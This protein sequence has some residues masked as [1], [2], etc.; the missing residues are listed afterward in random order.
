MFKNLIPNNHRRNRLANSRQTALNLTLLESRTVPAVLMTSGALASQPTWGIQPSTPISINPTT[1]YHGIAIVTRDIDNQPIDFNQDGFP[2]MAQ[3]GGNTGAVGYTSTETAYISF[4]RAGF[5]KIAFGSANGLVY[6]TKGGK[7]DVQIPLQFGGTQYAVADLNQDGFQDI[8]ALQSSPN[9]PGK[10]ITGHYLWD[11]TAQDFAHVEGTVLDVTDYKFGQMDLKDVNGDQIPDLV[12]PIF[13]T[14]PVNNPYN[15]DVTGYKVLPM[16]GFQVNLGVSDPTFGHWAGDFAPTAYTSVSLR[17]PNV[18]FGVPVDVSPTGDIRVAGPSTY[19]PVVNTVLVDLNGDG[20]RDL[21]I[22]EVD[23]ISLFANP[24]SGLFGQATGQFF[25]TAGGANGLN[26][27][28]GDFNNDGKPDLATSPNV[29]AIGLMSVVSPT[30]S[31][32]MANNSP[33]SVFLNTTQAAGAIDLSM[34]A[35]PGF[36]TSGF[37]WNGSLATADFNGD[38]NLDLAVGSGENQSTSY[39]I[40]EGDGQGNFGTMVRFNGYTNAADGYV[41]DFSR[42][43]NYLNVA[44]FN[45][46]GQVDVVVSSLNIGPGGS[47]QSTGKANSAV[48][49]TGLALNQTFGTPM[50][51]AAAIPAATVGQPYSQQLLVIGGDPSKPFAFALN[52][53]SVALPTGLTLSPTGL[54]SGTPTQTGPFQLILDISQPNGPRGTSMGTLMV[55]NAIPGVL[56]ISPATLPAGT[57]GTAYSQQLTVTGATGAVSWAVTS[58]ALPQGLSL[59]AGGL[60]SGTPSSTGAASFTVGATDSAGNTGYRQYSLTIGTN[61]TPPLAGPFIAAGQGQGGL[62]SIFNADGSQRS[63]FAPYGTG[64]KGSVTVA[65]GDVNGD[66][67]ADLV[68]GTGAGSEP[69]V[70]V[71]DGNTLAPIGSFYAYAQAFRGGVRVAAGDVN[72]DGKA[73]VVT[74]TGPGSAPNVCVFN[75]T[76]GT[77]LQSFYAYAPEY[78]G[79]INVAA[80]DVTGDGKADIV[81]GSGVGVSPH[82]VV[83]DSATAQALYSFYAYQTGFKGGVN[84]GTGD[85]DGDGKADI[86]TGAG[87]GADPH[88]KVFSG[89]DG[90][91]KQSFDAFPTGFNGGVSVASADLNNDGKDDIIAG[92]QT[93]S[94]QVKAFN[95]A[96]LSVIDDFFAFQGE[97]G[98]WVAGK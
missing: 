78:R 4:D 49:I 69:H 13:S 47:G 92:T 2:D 82:V 50:V 26:L 72:G 37:S 32:W 16:T 28:T 24:G 93:E 76:T 39:G 95:A 89:A 40:I 10:V 15:P 22:P 34:T 35:V 5:G 88:V 77:T 98:V 31:L 51:N 67:V 62:V 19:N 58:G 59:S 83:F 91:Q 38:G 63:T 73:E 84:V 75:G 87:P 27:L 70:M 1:F 56:T 61:P 55:N 43:L 74:G 41:N 46:D 21:V 20:L 97:V 23:G 79:G 80:G 53:A 44:D 81:T 66:G 36:S 33:L 18:Y 86:L 7:P 9:F 12:T 60:I 3:V 29:V 48:G 57:A 71:F 17:A 25:N 85:V 42:A 64:Y 6:S 68:T 90:T 96:D 14:V 65:Q 94:A 30:Y 52:P 11:N 8:L 45:R 54:I